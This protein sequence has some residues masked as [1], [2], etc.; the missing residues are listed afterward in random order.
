MK[1]YSWIQFLNLGLLLLGLSF[2]FKFQSKMFTFIR[3]PD[4]FLQGKH[5]DFTS[6]W[7]DDYG[8]MTVFNM[9]LEIGIPH[10]LP[11]AQMLF[12]KLRKIWDRGCCKDSTRS[13]QFFQSDYEKLYIGPEFALDVRLGQIVVF[14]WV[15]FMY[16]VGLPVLFAISALN[17]TI[18]YWVDKYLLLRFY[19]TPPNYDES[20]IHEATGFMSFAF[21]LH[22]IT[23]FFMISNH[24][25]MN[26]E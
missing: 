4:G 12:W 24:T 1:G 23:G 18:M 21:F 25:L 26:H 11:T 15:T 2:N 22:A 5:S 8:F 17:F 9:G 14:V 6:A 7:F 3:N 13:K 10:M 16:S 19:R 20:T